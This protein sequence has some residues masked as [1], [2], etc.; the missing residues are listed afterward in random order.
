MKT[1]KNQVS[2]DFEII[3]VPKGK[4]RL[5]KERCKGCSFCIEFCPKKVLELSPEYNLKGYHFPEVT[6]P[7]DCIA[8][9]FCGVICP[10]FAVYCEAD[11]SPTVK[12]KDEKTVEPKEKKAK[13]KNND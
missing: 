7:E 1:K 9:N 2:S 3:K 5:L 10:D 13:S 12:T 4:M 8:C 6:R 11:L